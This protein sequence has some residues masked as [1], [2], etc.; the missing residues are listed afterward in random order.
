MQSQSAADSCD[1]TFIA[2]YNELRRLA[3]SLR[4]DRGNV[5]LNATALVHEAYIRISTSETLH[6]ESPLHLKYLVV[7]AMKH[8][9]LDAARRK[10]ALM[11]GGGDAPMRRVPL[12]DP[13]ARSAGTDP[14]QLLAMG[15]ALD[16]LAERDDVQARAFELQ[17]FGG[18]RVAEIAD[19]LNLSEKTVQRRLRQARAV[20][21]LALDRSGTI[22]G[23]TEGTTADEPGTPRADYRTLRSS[24]G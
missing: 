7:R 24:G 10:A 3:H 15:I 19:L 5:T 14:R 18:L 6:V 22:E 8:V 17:Y 16:E 23:T 21:A 20:L 12:D 13:A 4:R 1:E 11:R 2:A 9:L